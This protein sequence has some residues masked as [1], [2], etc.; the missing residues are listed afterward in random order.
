MP[1]K[2][3]ALGQ[4]HGFI[5]DTPTKSKPQSYT[6]PEFIKEYRAKRDSFDWTPDTP[7]PQYTGEKFDILAIA[8]D[9][10]KWNEQPA[11]VIEVKETKPNKR[12]EFHLQAK[13][14]NW[15][16][17]T[18]PGLLF[19]ADFAA[20][21][22]LPP[23][24]AEARKVQSCLDKYPDLTILNPR[25]GYMGLFIEIK[26]D[27]G[28]PYRKDGKT[29]LSSAHITAQNKTLTKLKSLGYCA[30]FGVGEAQIKR[31]IVK[32]MGF[33]QTKPIN[34]ML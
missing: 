24:I 18:W 9:V 20:G 8:A 12:S 11:K 25:G 13:I 34:I 22:F 17:D 7:P 33:E 2:K 14:C 5:G 6:E 31:I 23:W 27:A 3:F 30:C 1:K 16:N 15:L 29:L 10:F 32:Y 26:T 19:V 28:T 21:L 4:T